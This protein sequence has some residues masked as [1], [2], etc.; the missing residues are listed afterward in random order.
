MWM[1]STQ[2]NILSSR[3]LVLS[4]KIHEHVTNN[5]LNYNKEASRLYAELCEPMLKFFI[6]VSRNEP[7]H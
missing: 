7:D 5:H 6:L 4:K 1:L 2:H 3:T